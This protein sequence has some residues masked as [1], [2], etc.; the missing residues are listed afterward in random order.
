[1]QTIRACSFFLHLANIAEDRHC[2]RRTRPR[3][4]RLSAAR[5]E[6]Q[7]SIAALLAIMGQSMLLETTPLLARSI[8]NRFSYVDPLNHL[9]IELLKRLCADGADERVGQGIR[10]TVNGIAAGLRNSGS[11]N[12][13][14]QRVAL[15]F[16]AWH[17][18]RAR[19]SGGSDQQSNGLLERSRS[20]FCGAEMRH[21]ARILRG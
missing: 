15:L 13:D 19:V 11:R 16:S 7:D 14:R 12:H 9:Q 10:L 18:A 17:V 2:I 8:R 1:V 3:A 21:E 4:Y 5:A 6:W 20:V